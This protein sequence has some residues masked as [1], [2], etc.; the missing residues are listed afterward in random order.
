MQESHNTQLSL[1]GK[2]A[3]SIVCTNIVYSFFLQKEYDL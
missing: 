3:L 1:I 2:A